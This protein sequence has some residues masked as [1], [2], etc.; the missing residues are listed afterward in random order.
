MNITNHKLA[1][2]WKNNASQEYSGFF[3]L[4]KEMTCICADGLYTIIIWW[5][6]S[7]LFTLKPNLCF[8]NTL[9]YIHHSACTRNTSSS[10]F[11]YCLFSSRINAKSLFMNTLEKVVQ[12]NSI[13]SLTNCDNGSTRLIQINTGYHS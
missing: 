13:T 1:F 8:K 7:F 3:T 10:V 5:L 4:T 2:W 12:Q 9:L 6:W 11:H